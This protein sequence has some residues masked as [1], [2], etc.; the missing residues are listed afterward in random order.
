MIDIL[1]YRMFTYTFVAVHDCVFDMVRHDYAAHM[2][3]SSRKHDR[4]N[5]GHVIM[6]MQVTWSLPRRSD[7]HVYAGHIVMTMHVI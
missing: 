6:T 1:V 5:A 2:V 4:D 7:G 3:I